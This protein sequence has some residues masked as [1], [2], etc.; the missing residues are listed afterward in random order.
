MFY[1]IKKISSYINRHRD[2]PI[3]LFK[4]PMHFIISLKIIKKL[5]LKSSYPL[6]S[7]NTS[8]STVDKE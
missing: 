8:K 7:V 3:K 4:F 6:I 2:Q 5:L 1:F